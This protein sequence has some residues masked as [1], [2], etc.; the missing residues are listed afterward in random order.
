MAPPS[1]FLADV[2][3]VCLVKLNVAQMCI[4]VY[5]SRICRHVV[6]TF[7]GG[8]TIDSLGKILRKIYG[9]KGP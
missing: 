5:F 3:L 9:G 6:R 4:A 7:M 2:P 1:Q 8:S